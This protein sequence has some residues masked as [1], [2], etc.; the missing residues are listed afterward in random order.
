M[1]KTSSIAEIYWFIHGSGVTAGPH[2]LDL[3]PSADLVMTNGLTL[4]GVGT[5]R[6]IRAHWALHELGLQYKCNPILP[7]SGEPRHR[8]TRAKCASENSPVAGR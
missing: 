3:R 2:E 4:W 1:T 7:R 6:T 5:T 8:N